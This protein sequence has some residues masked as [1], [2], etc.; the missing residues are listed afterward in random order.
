MIKGTLIVPNVL[1]RKPGI[2]YWID[3][4]GN[5]RGAPQRN[6]KKGGKKGRRFGKIKK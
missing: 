4:D 3:K 2:F 1:I 5:V 6:G